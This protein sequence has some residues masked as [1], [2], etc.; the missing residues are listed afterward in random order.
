M[1]YWPQTHIYGW[2]IHKF[3]NSEKNSNKVMILNTVVPMTLPPISEQ[4][5]KS[6]VQVRNILTICE[7]L[8]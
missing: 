7:L 5:N 4:C 3:I 1:L 2:P 6:F 8:F